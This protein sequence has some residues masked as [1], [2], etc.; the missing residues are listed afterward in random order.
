M[1]GRDRA[2]SVYSHGICRFDDGRFVPARCWEPS[3]ADGALQPLGEVRGL[4]VVG[5]R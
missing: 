4:Q 3:F 5:C 1:S 2:R